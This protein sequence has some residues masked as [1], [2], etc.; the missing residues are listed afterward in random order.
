M[1]ICYLLS[2]CTFYLCSTETWFE[3]RN[4]DINDISSLNR[5][6][7]CHSGL[8]LNRYLQAHP[9]DTGKCPSKL[10]AYMSIVPDLIFKDVHI[11]TCLWILYLSMLWVRVSVC[12]CMHVCVLMRIPSCIDLL[13]CHLFVSQVWIFSYMYTT[14]WINDFW[15]L[16]FLFL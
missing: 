2:F 16:I 8:S 10:T 6:G 5:G 14:Y 12:V 7:I 1:Y 4:N 3:K 15:F 11:C 13:P 9:G